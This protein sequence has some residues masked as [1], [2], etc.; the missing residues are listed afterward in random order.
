VDQNDTTLYA[1]AITSAGSGQ[2]YNIG[3]NDL[4]AASTHAGGQGLVFTASIAF[5]LTSAVIQADAA[6][7]RTIELKSS[8]GTLLGSKE[9]Y[10]PAGENRVNIGLAIPIGVDMEIGFPTNSHLYREGPGVTFPFTVSNVVSIT[11]GTFDGYYYYLY[12]W[13]IAVGAVTPEVCPSERKAVAVTMDPLGPDCSV[14]SIGTTA[15]NQT[16]IAYPNPT[17]GHFFLAHDGD[18]PV[19]IMNASGLEVVHFDTHHNQEF[20]LSIASGVYYVHYE[21]SGAHH[22]ETLIIK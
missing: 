7:N 5:T 14:A 6:G 15:A 18:S 2:E 20:N 1:Q 3:L 8:T 22:V 10:V 12:D 4:S 19:H 17:S 16:T 11:N 9:I 13:S 21:S